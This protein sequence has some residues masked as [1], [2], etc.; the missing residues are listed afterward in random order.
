MYGTFKLHEN[1]INQYK[2]IDC[3]KVPLAV[4]K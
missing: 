1:E 2:T 3:I 4:V